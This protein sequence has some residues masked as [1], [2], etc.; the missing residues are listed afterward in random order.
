MEHYNHVWV[1]GLVWKKHDVSFNQL[2][3]QIKSNYFWVWL[4]DWSTSSSS[5]A[6]KV[7]IP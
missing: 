7:A 5:L 6:A 4:L 2:V 1:T 3:A